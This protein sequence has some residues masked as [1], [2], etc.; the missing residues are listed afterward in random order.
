MSLRKKIEKKTS[1]FI[2]NVYTQRIKKMG[3]KSQYKP[4]NRKVKNKNKEN[5][6]NKK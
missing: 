3:Q 6:I 5:I 2:K 4:E 1:T